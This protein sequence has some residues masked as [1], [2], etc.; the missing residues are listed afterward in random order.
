MIEN[1]ILKQIF[2]QKLFANKSCENFLA[3]VLI[4]TH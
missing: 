4:E 1:I 3:L 2:G